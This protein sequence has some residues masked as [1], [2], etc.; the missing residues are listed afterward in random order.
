VILGHGYS[1][2]RRRLSFQSTK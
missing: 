2:R 1:R